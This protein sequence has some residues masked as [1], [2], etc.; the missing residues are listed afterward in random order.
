[1][2][3][4]QLA[5]AVEIA[6][7]YRGVIA[8]GVGNDLFRGY[9][10][11]LQVAPEVVVFLIEAEHLAV[12]T[13]AMS[14]EVDLAVHEDQVALQDVGLVLDL[15]VWVFLKAV[16]ADCEHHADGSIGSEC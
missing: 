8:G 11:L 5:Q 9:S 3:G 4:L 12:A 7:G 13:S 14:P 2:L 16:T 6:H 1:M 10:P 15:A